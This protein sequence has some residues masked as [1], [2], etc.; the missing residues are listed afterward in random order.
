MGHPVGFG[1]NCADVVPLWKKSTDFPYA[2]GI[3]GFYLRCDV[4]KTSIFPRK[5]DIAVKES[6]EWGATGADGMPCS[7]GP[8][9]K[10]G[11]RAA[12]R[13]P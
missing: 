13:V 12:R 1:R 4:E 8:E 5:V 7:R 2:A 9:G 10:G 11:I 6:R 3:E